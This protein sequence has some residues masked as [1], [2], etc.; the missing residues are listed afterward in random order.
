MLLG[1]YRCTDIPGEFLWQ[2]GILT[3]AVLSGKWLLLED[4]DCT[5]TDVVSVIGH[6]VKTKTLSVPGYRDCIRVKSGFQLFVTMRTASEGTQKPVQMSIPFQKHWSCVNV[7]P[8]SKEE[9]V[10][11]VQMSFP[12]LHTIATKIVDVF[13]LFSVGNHDDNAVT[14][15][16]N[17]RQISTR[18][19]IKWCSRAVVDFDVSSPV[20]A[21]K[22]FQDALDVFCC[23]VSNCGM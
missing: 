10:T 4:I 17:A 8:L 16:K 21:L 14:T 5:A 19:L 13:L 9:L 23:S 2:P 22:I 18:D 12:L 7:E 6:L 1:M 20:S 15:I 11:V 3:E